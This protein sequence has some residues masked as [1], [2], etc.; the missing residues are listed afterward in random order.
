MLLQRRA[1]AAP[2]GILI[3]DVSG[4]SV[5]NAEF[6]ASALKVAD[7]LSS[8]GVGKGDY[9]ITLFDNGIHAQRIWIGIAWSGAVEVPVNPEFQGR[10]LTY[11]LNDSQAATIITSGSCLES[12]R[13]IW[14]ELPHLKNVITVDECDQDPQIGNISLADLEANAP[15]RRHTAPSLEDPYGVIYTSGTTGASKGVLSPW[16]SLQYSVLNQIFASDLTQAYD[17]PAFY[18]PW[19]VFHASG[20]TGLAFAAHRNARLVMRDRLSTSAFWRDIKEYRCTHTHLLGLAGWLMAQAPTPTDA[21]NPLERVLMNPVIAEF[22]EFER[23][24]GVTVSTGWGMTEIGFPLADG[25]LGDARTCGKLAPVYEARIV[26][27]SDHEV[28][29]G[30]PGEF[31]VKPHRPWLLFRGYLN[32]PEATNARWQDGWFHTEDVLRADE[33]GNYYFV[34]RLSDYIR[35]RGNNV[36]SVELEAEIRAHPEVAE[37]AAVGISSAQLPK[38][39]SASGGE[40]EILI[41]VQKTSPGSLTEDQLFADLAEHLPKYM[42]PRF[43]QFVDDFPRT[44]TGKIQK[45][46][47]K[48]ETLKPGIWD[49]ASRMMRLDP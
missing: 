40:D 29:A 43:I 25:P 34:D 24:F 20:R 32:K 19:P 33:H 23:R 45:K 5:T 4:R 30:T 39:L 12:I 8:L 18:S 11:S 3:Q 35:V 47:L 36:S 37:V 9:V 17:D 21:D 42:L 10:I 49:R 26:D 7:A 38:E 15:C 6:H 13:K 48:A 1:E 14:H 46:L 44:P 27:E 16:G 41:L 28:P 22:K 31:V 2:D